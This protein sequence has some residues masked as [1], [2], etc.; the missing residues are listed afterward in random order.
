MLCFQSK[1]CAEQRK[2][3]SNSY[4]QGSF[5]HFKSLQT[6][7]EMSKQLV[8]SDGKNEPILSTLKVDGKGWKIGL[9]MDTD[10]ILKYLCAHC[11]SV[12]CDAVEL[13]CD[14]DD[15][16][17]SLY[18]NKCLTELIQNNGNKCIINSH[19]NPSIVAVRSVR[20]QIYESMVIC[21]FSTFK[22]KYQEPDAAGVGD[23]VDTFGNGLKDERKEH[24][25]QIK[26]TN[27][28]LGCQWK[29]SFKDL[30]DDHISKCAMIFAPDIQ[31]SKI[32]SLEAENMELKTHFLAKDEEIQQLQIQLQQQFEETKLN[33]T[34]LNFLMMYFNLIFIQI[35]DIN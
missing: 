32:K 9:F 1:K 2:K 29:G 27:T 26:A 12:C 10:E 30:I 31:L 14:H 24:N 5:T 22:R 6:P 28:S 11:N 23:V 18:C 34:R 13:G 3:V 20:R 33:D 19:C 21:P 25:Q 17:I 35:V 8:R 16:D 15:N 7:K 4:P